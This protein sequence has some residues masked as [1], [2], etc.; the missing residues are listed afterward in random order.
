MTNSD[1]IFCRI[2]AGEIPSSKVYETDRFLAF[3]D[4]APKAP[5][6][7]L[8]IPKKHI[9][10]IADIADEDSALMGELMLAVRNIAAQQGISESFRLV[11]NNGAESGQS[12]FHVHMHILAG[13][14]MSDDLG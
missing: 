14:R 3:N 12:V 10:R 1:C 13:R 7:I 6:H 8:V 11:S 4:I 2:V 5:T 9:A